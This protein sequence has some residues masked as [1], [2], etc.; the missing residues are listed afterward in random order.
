MLS[1]ARD[2]S[3][4][5]WRDPALPPWMRALLGLYLFIYVWSVPMLML[6]L[7]PVWGSG[8]GGFLLILQGA[9]V[10]LWLVRAAGR[11]GAVAAGVILGGSY[12]LEY[13][14]VTRGVPFGQYQYTTT[15]GLQVGGAVPLAIPFAWLM[16]V[17][18]AVML[19]ARLGRAVVVVPLA[20]L[21]ALLLDV[22]IEPVAAYVTGYWQW[23]AS[24][25]FYG[26][27][28]ANFLAWGGAALVLASL[29]WLIVPGLHRAV[30][31]GWLPPLLF[32]LNAL[33]FTLVNA[34]H[35][36]WWS[37]LAGGLLL[38]AVWRLQRR[39]GSHFPW[40]SDHQSTSG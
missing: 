10:G 16:V 40:G 19:V 29:L 36:Y 38:C 32:M 13:V 9:L 25:P 21:L 17:P 1:R 11:R 22:L 5:L 34:A 35:G 37:V 14:G 27:P 3:R 33:Q 24:G 28:T 23:V 15:L 6:D 31:A 39:H 7:V 8:M 20:A 26:V 2:L 4:A 30:P 12:L 18:G